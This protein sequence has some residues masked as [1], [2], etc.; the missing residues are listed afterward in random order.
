MQYQKANKEDKKVIRE[1]AKKHNI[2]GVRQPLHAVMV[3]KQN[4]RLSEETARAF[5]ADL[6]E[7]GFIAEKN[8]GPIFDIF[9]VWKLC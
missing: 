7:V 4:A 2:N 8:D 5:E 1:I 3:G 9:M 6:R